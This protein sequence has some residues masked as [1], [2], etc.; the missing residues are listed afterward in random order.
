MDLVRGIAAGLI[1]LS[2][3]MLLVQGYGDIPLPQ[4][5][6]TLDQVVAPFRVPTLIFLSGM[7]LSRSMAKGSRRYL[8]GKLRN[9]AWPYLVWVVV[10]TA[11]SWPVWSLPGVLL[12]GTYLWFLLFLFVYYLAALA[13]RRVPAVVL[14]LVPL[15]ASFLAPDGTKYG[16]RLLYLFALFMAGHLVATR[17]A[18]WEWLTRSRSAVLVAIALVAVHV[19]A[20]FEYGYGPQSVLVTA[21]GIVLVVRAARVLCRRRA[22][23][24]LLFAGRAS[25]VYYVSHYPVIAATVNVAVALGLR[26]V[27]LLVA[28]NVVVALTVATVLALLRDRAPVSW[29]FEPPQLGSGT[30]GKGLVRPRE[31]T[32]PT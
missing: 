24:P 31:A 17:G 5:A 25:L 26:S 14:V 1:V 27:P 16:E 28:I 29:L 11:L 20:S 32:R 30:G 22:A 12:G 15:A 3:A 4:W 8:I 13:L 7:L 10:F 9:I 19:G 23:A 2:H 18:A 21:G 6:L